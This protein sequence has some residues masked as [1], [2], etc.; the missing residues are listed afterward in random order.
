MTSTLAYLDPGS[1]GTIIQMI[2]GAGVAAV[3]VTMKFYGR[4]ILR[5]LHGRADD[6]EAPS[7]QNPRTSYGSAVPA[8]GS[9]SIRPLH[10]R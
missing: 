3:G 8:I 10:L 9:G 6:P 2:G 1:A 4:K 7:E 5:R